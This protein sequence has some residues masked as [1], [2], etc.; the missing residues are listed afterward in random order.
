[1]AKIDLVKFNNKIGQFTCIMLNGLL[2]G[3]CRH[4]VTGRQTGHWLRH[5]LKKMTERDFTYSFV[6]VKS[7]TDYV[8][9][10]L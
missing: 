3:Y 2:V 5:Q 6:S 8:M 10:L 9:C 4:S 1:V 7:S